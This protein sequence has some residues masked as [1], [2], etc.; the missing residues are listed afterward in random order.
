MFNQYF[1]CRRP[2][3]DTDAFV[4]GE[5]SRV[6]VFGAVDEVGREAGVGGDFAQA[7]GVGAVLRA[8]DE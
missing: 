3:G 4:T 6:D 7:V 8:D 1:R 2:S 5:P